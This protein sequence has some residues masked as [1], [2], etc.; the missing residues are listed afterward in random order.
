MDTEKNTTEYTDTPNGADDIDGAIADGAEKALPPTD[1]EDAADGLTEPRAF[2]PAD[3]DNT[4]DTAEIAFESDEVLFTELAVPEDEALDGEFT[5]DEGAP[6]FEL[7][8][9]EDG[10]FTAALDADVQEATEN[11]TIDEPADTAEDTLADTIEEKPTQI[12]APREIGKRRIDGIFDF[13]EL[14]IFTLVGVLI[15]TSFFFRHSEVVGD[16]MMHTLH[17]GDRLIISDLFYEP[18]YGDIIVVED[19]EA[20]MRSPIVKRVIATEGET[21]RITYDAISVNGAEL[22]EEY[23]FTDGHVYFY[24]LDPSPFRDNETLVYLPGQYVEFVVPEGEIFAL[25]DHRNN[26]SDSRH[27][28]T[29][30]EDSVLGRVILRFYP[31]PD[32]EIFINK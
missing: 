9:G 10:G 24:E 32:F 30:R 17:N 18:E 20:G 29:M 3:A 8:E 11:A 27:Y 31:F 15:V 21:V 6:S 12:K 22:A 2:A 13:L 14:F 16:S 1:T 7:I 25:G 23:V 19:R 26:S 4:E 5:F 28:G